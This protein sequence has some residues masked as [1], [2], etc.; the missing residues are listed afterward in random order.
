MARVPLIDSPCPLSQAEQLRI[1]GHCG[2]CHKTVHALDGL[3]DDQRR[4]LFAAA[5]GPLCVSYRTTVRRGPALGAAMAA[6]LS[7]GAAMA[8]Q[9]CDEAKP[10]FQSVES[11]P[12][13]PFTVSGEEPGERLDS[14]VVTG[15]GV[16]PRDAVW[17]DEADVQAQEAAGGSELDDRLDTIVMG[18]IK[19]SQDA[20]WVDDSTLPDLP[21]VVET[22]SGQPVDASL[23]LSAAQKP[24]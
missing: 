2:R 23:G 17:V 13:T 14:I 20:A 7:A 12:S 9:D 8:G 1:D 6:M 15:G 24:R 22:E 19:S 5:K 21:I 10:V 11:S 3:D 4:A 16:R 18:G